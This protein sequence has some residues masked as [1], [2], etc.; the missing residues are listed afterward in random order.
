M[1]NITANSDPLSEVAFHELT[2]AAHYNKAGNAW[3][4]DFVDSELNN[5]VWRSNQNPPYGNG[6]QGAISDII[7]LGE[8][9][10]YHMG[11]F[12]S[13]QKYG[14]NSTDVFEQ[15]IRYQ[16]N[17]PI[18]GFSSHINLLE[19]FSP[20]RTADPD[21]WI[22]QGLYYDLM[23]NRNDRI[24]TGNFVLP[25]DNVSNYTNQQFFNALDADITS[26]PAYRQR[27]LDENANNQAADV[28][29]L[30]SFYNY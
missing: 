24:V 30:F 20:Q 23:D 4:N 3:W 8:S 29:S 19:D 15:G 13:D 2:H 14:L 12:M 18:G 1:T 26:L 25:D 17:N 28:I 9:W 22:P 11:H 5:I 7:A 27:L 10:A 6:N 21:R 16:N